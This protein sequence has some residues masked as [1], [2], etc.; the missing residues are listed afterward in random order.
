MGAG[1]RGGE[2]PFQDDA[3]PSVTR[4]RE[5]SG[6]TAWVIASS[7]RVHVRAPGHSHPPASIAKPTG[8]TQRA[9]RGSRCPGAGTRRVGLVAERARWVTLGASLVVLERT[10]V[11]PSPTLRSPGGEPLDPDPEPRHVVMAPTTRER[12]AL[13]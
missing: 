6:C 4:R 1:Q 7:P 8:A 5:L 9:R 10:C 3:R 13:P 2:L 11:V 12:R